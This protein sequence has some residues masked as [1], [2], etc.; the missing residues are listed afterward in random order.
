MSDKKFD[1]DALID[2][3]APLLGLV[4]DDASRPIVRTHLEIAAAMA[5]LLSEAKLEDQQEPAPVFVP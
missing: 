5:A 2:A 3:A 4:V 1:A